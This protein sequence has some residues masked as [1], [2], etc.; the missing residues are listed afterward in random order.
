MCIRILL[1]A[2]QGMLT[3]PSVLS[4]RILLTTFMLSPTKA[5]AL[6]GCIL[7]HPFCCTQSVDR[8]QPPYNLALKV[9]DFGLSKRCR[10]GPTL[11]VSA[12][13]DRPCGAL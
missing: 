11:V 7:P 1:C 2:P 9:A 12:L 4:Q 3:V 5:H 8:V 13:C 10:S 6:L